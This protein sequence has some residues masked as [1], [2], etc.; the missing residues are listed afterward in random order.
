M[1]FMSAGDASWQLWLLIACIQAGLLRDAL[2]MKT[3]DSFREVYNWRAINCLE[4]WGRVVA[5]HAERGGLC[6]LVYPVV[7]LLLA[8]ARLVPSPRWFPVRLRL[9]RILNA[10]ASATSVFVP[11]APLLL[12]VLAWPGFT[13]KVSGTGKCPDLLQ[14]LQVSKTNL[15]LASVQQELVEQVSLY[16]LSSLGTTAHDAYKGRRHTH[17]FVFQYFPTP[18]QAMELLSGNLALSARSPG[19]PELAHL[20]ALALRRFVKT[21]QA[22]RFRSQAT[23]LLNA[24]DENIKFVGLSRDSVDFTPKDTEA[25]ST[26]L[27]YVSLDLVAHSYQSVN[28]SHSM[29]LQKSA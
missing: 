19:F 3:V 7:Q 18:F 9:A 5:A 21:S 16:Q 26:F 11:V 14:Q 25:A 1:S 22:E 4:L 29:S 27:Q 20:P 15:K 13:Q 10:V 28:K 12:E 6:H 17:S 8:A 2:T 24:I 23:L